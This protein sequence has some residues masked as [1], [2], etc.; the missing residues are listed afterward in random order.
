MKKETLSEKRVRILDIKNVRGLYYE[1]DVKQ[2][3]KEILE[4]ID[5]AK[6]EVSDEQTKAVLDV[7]KQEIRQKIGEELLK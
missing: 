1:E 2:F 3:I 6:A 5:N 4:E 7:L